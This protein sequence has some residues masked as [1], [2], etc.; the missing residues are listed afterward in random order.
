MCKHITGRIHSIDARKQEIINHSFSNTRDSVTGL[1]KYEQFVKKVQDYINTNDTPEHGVAIVYSDIRYFKLINEKYG[2]AVGDSLLEFFS[3]SIL[4]S[5]P[6]NI[7][8]CRVYSDNIITLVAFDNSLEYDEFVGIISDYNHYLE[9]ELQS[10]FLHQQIRI[11]TGI[12]ISKSTAG[13][14]AEVIISN[15]NMARKTAKSLESVDAILFTPSMMENLVMEMELCS[16]L[17]YAIENEELTVFYQPKIECGSEKLIGAEALV[18]WIKPDGT[19]VY[20]DKFI[21][22]FESNGLIVEVDYF[23]YRKVFEHI[24]NRLDKNLPTVPISMNVSRVHLSSDSIIYY[25]KSLFEQYPIPPELIEFEVTENIYIKNMHSVVPLIKALRNMGIRVSMDDFGAGYSSLNELNNLP[26]DILKLDRVFMTETLNEKQQIIL[27][28]IIDM[29][30][31]LNIAVLCEGVETFSQNDFLQKIGCDMVQ[32]YYHSKPLCEDDFTRYMKEHAGKGTSYIHFSFDKSLWAD[33]HTYEGR[34]IGDGVQ[35]VSGPANLPALHFDGSQI[36]NNVV[37]F[38]TNIY[39]SSN[40]SISMWFREDEIQLES[41]IMYT[42]FNDGY[43]DIVPHSSDMKAL[44]KIKDTIHYSAD[45]SDAGGVIS[46]KHHIWNLAVATYNARTQTSNLYINGSYAGKC[47]HVPSLGKSVRVLLGGDVYK[48]SF[49]GSIADLRIY[50]QE[51][52]HV[53]VLYI[54]NELEI[55]S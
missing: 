33:T 1:F 16:S 8:A 2:Y 23:V 5:N 32:G 39:P 38:P 3:K 12:F 14:N 36:V 29:A 11:N 15:A 41:S 27:S 48:N 42:S 13:L 9:K 35:Y 18:R 31:R 22:L 7:V 28:C 51:L 17:P 49:K 24:K 10:R 53:E 40:F 20:P 25:I 52:S 19:M 37:D 6:S 30:K 45:S 34:I 43:I 54:F 50:D 55:R 4:N 21:P 26:I 47:S 44:F 46:P